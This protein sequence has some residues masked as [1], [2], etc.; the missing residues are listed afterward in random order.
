MTISD[1]LLMAYVDGELDTQARSEVERAI[2]SD[3]EVARRVSRQRVLRDRLRAA[4]DGVLSEPVPDRL[5]AAARGAPATSAREGNQEAGVIDLAQT[6]ADRAAAQRARR[7][8]SW[9][10]W[11]AI[12]ASVVLGAVIGHLALSQRDIVPFTSADGRLVAR[13]GLADALTN[14]LASTQS[15][16]SATRI[17]VSF[18]SKTRQYCRT[19]VT[20]AGG[21]LAGL[22]CRES[23]G[24]TLEGLARAPA[25]S[26]GTETYATAGSSLPTAVMQTL[27]EQIAGEPLDAAAEAAAQKSGWR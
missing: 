5:V 23:N 20:H 10:E 19:F 25:K 8:W 21:G 7:R 18:R 12:A 14:Q 22:A 24:W 26:G 2:E 15:A 16:D 1:E 6:R 4:F 17:G 11:S 9:P 3:P 13:G 27:Q